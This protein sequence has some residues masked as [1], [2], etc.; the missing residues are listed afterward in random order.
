[1]G[2]YNKYSNFINVADGVFLGIVSSPIS[3]V[4]HLG[5]KVTEATPTTGEGDYKTVV[6]LN[7]LPKTRM[8]TMILYYS[9]DGMPKGLNKTTGGFYRTNVDPIYKTYT[10]DEISVSP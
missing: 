1:M 10:I 3:L 9:T 2:E 8:Q 7:V 6:Q 4:E 5:F